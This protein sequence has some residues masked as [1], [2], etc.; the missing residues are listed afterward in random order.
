MDFALL[1]SSLHTPH[2]NQDPENESHC[3]LES[4]KV[5][6]LKMVCF[7]LCN[8]FPSFPYTFGLGV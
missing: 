7:L 1:S 4:V 6:S 8:R 3:S 5:G 2:A